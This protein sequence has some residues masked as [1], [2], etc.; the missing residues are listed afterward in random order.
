[1]GACP[2]LSR[3]KRSLRQLAIANLPSRQTLEMTSAA[4]V[5]GPHPVFS[6][7]WQLG[8]PAAEHRPDHDGRAPTRHR[9]VLSAQRAGVHQRRPRLRHRCRPD[10]AVRDAAKDWE[11]AGIGIGSGRPQFKILFTKAHDCSTAL[12]T[13]KGWRANSPHGHRIAVLSATLAA[14]SS[15]LWSPLVAPSASTAMKTQR[16]QAAA[17]SRPLGGRSAE[18]A[19]CSPPKRDGVELADSSRSFAPTERPC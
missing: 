7:F 8:P 4:V 12:R 9:H 18:L 1:M 19:H 15:L 16:S 2:R 11:M 17:T 5:I 14:G 3:Y 10:G 13:L 6:G